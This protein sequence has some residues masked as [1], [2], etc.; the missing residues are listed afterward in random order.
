M[1]PTYKNKDHVYRF[2]AEGLVM[3]QQSQLSVFTR[4]SS[5]NN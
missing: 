1:H 2:G 5:A 3:K 4:S